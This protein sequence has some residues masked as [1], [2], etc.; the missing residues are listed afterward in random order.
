MSINSKGIYK[1][2]QSQ[3]FMLRLWQEDLGSGEADWRGKV[4]HVNSG[5]AIYFR[6]W[7]TLEDFLEKLA[8]GINLKDLHDDGG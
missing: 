3:L 5:E 4:Q 8:F 7:H 1:V 2:Q 6:D